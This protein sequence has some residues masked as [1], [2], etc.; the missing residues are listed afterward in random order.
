MS[1]EITYDADGYAETPEGQAWKLW[2]FGG[3]PVSQ[4]DRAWFGSFN[5]EARQEE[6]QAAAEADA[7][8][9]RGR[10]AQIARQARAVTGPG[11]PGRFPAAMR[12]SRTASRRPGMAEKDADF[13]DGFRGAG[14]VYAAIPLGMPWLTAATVGVTTYMLDV[15][16]GYPAEMSAEAASAAYDA[17]AGYSAFLDQGQAEQIADARGD[18]TFTRWE[19]LTGYCDMSAAAAAQMREADEDLTSGLAGLRE[20]GS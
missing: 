19:G 20:A 4:A 3:E 16:Y 7:A 15:P 13:P 14:P 2:V 10:T 5:A 1:A 8:E 9:S 6:A 18:G 17:Y 12:R 11:A